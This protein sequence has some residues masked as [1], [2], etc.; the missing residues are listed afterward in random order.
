MTTENSWRIQI[1]PKLADGT[2]INLRA[3]NS[4]EA[5]AI[6]KWATENARLITDTLAAFTGTSAVTATIPTQSVESTGQS[7]GGQPQAAP[8]VQQPAA[9]PEGRVC[10]H[11]QMVYKTGSSAKG[12]WQGYFCPTPKGTPGQ[13]A[14]QFIR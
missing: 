5:E 8:P 14:P 3:E 1:S 2:L 9:Q 10:Q 13:C 12:P 7:W 6:L 4:A 11:G